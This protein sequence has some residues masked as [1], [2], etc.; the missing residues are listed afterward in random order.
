MRRR[1]FIGLL[2]AMATWPLTAF[3][4]SASIPTVGFLFAGSFSTVK[5]PLS[6]FRDALKQTGYAE[7]QNLRVQYREA[8]GQYARLPALAADLVS[9]R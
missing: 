6:A 4:Q 2:G 9:R 8:A 7:G 5:G 1:V 3:G